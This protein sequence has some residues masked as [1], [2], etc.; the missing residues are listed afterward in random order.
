[1]AL[2]ILFSLKTTIASKNV[3]SKKVGLQ[4]GE[5]D[6]ASLILLRKISKSLGDTGTPFT[7]ILSSIVIKCGEVKSPTLRLFS[8]AAA[9]S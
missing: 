3:T 8:F 5:I 2:S 7:L 6:A 1:M 4:T 9:E